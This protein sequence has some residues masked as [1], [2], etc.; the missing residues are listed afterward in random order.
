MWSQKIIAVRKAGPFIAVHQAA[1]RRNA[2]D[3]AL[4]SV[5]WGAAA[6]EEAANWL[7]SLL[8]YSQAALMAIYR[9]VKFGT[10][11][12][13]PVC[14]CSRSPWPY[15][16][17]DP[18]CQNPLQT[19]VLLHVS[20]AVLKRRCIKYVRTCLSAVVSVNTVKPQN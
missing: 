17:Y 15:F 12:Q 16:S 10:K 5:C 18:S 3:C 13:H 6:A 4:P 9:V 7:A 2:Q 14:L 8:H 1:S 11:T 20:L 19:K